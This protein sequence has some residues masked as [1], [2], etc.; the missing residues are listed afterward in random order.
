ME[1]SLETRASLDFG[2]DWEQT[3]VMRFLPVS[4]AVF[5][6]LAGAATCASAQESSK[7]YLN[8]SVT[9]PQ[10]RF[11]TG[12]EKDHFKVG[13]NGVPTRITGFSDA[14][15]PISIAVVSDEPLTGLA[16]PGAGDELIQARSVF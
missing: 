7:R 14:G 5:M 13:A 12:L 4:C 6:M 11:I 2:F 16:L 1:V 8:V 15:S 9:D 10:H 3:T